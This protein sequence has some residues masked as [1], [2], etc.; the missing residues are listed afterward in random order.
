MI[1]RN[2]DKEESPQKLARKQLNEMHMY[3]SK[4]QNRVNFMERE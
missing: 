3:E 2:A 4:I 1:L